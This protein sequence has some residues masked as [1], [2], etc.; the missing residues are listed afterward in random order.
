VPITSATSFE[1][2][3][4]V[5]QMV[6]VCGHDNGPSRSGHSLGGFAFAFA[7]DFGSGGGFAF[8]CGS[9]DVC[10]HHENLEVP[11]SV[12]REGDAG[13]PARTGTLGAE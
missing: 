2:Y 13:P 10:I 6:L 4:S 9:G 12:T 7:F 5:K 8:G 1:T 11:I 3:C